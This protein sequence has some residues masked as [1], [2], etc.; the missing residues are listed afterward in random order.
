[1]VASVNAGIAESIEHGV[2]TSTS[3]M[4]N[5]PGFEDAVMRLK[6]L[7]AAGLNF[8]V[9][10]HFNVVAGSAL[11]GASSLTDARG[12]FRS[13]SGQMLNS[14][15]GRIDPEEVRA[16][17]LA[18]LQKARECLAPLGLK[19]THIDSHRH[20]HCLPGVHEVV[21]DCARSGAVRHVR[22][23]VEAPGLRIRRSFRGSVLQLLLGSR[24]PFDDIGFAGVSAM[25]SATFEDDVL[26]MLERLP[27]GTTELMVHPGHDSD[28]LAILD[29]Y[30]GPRE[31]EL[32]ALKSERVKA[33][34]SAGAIQLVH[35]GQ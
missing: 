3:L 11:D 1:M 22:N 15:L 34:I 29:H 8:G 23:P 32:K 18:Q 6:Q 7:V 21:R 24:A 4:V 35:F 27:D 33:Q 10:L 20:A 17:F 2:V 25:A 12:R 13:L 31:V 28:E 16:E 5:M 9:G 19:V 26:W 14:Y 30:R